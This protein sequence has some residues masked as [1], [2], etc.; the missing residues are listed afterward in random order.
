MEN[1][2]KDRNIKQVK[3]LPGHRSHNNVETVKKPFGKAMKIGQFQN[4]S[5]K[6]TLSSLLV[7]CGDTPHSATGIFPA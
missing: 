7:N 6:G 5:G 3:T 4:Q 2:T 1:V